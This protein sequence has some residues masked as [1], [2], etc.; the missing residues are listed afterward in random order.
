VVTLQKGKN[1]KWKV[2]KLRDQATWSEGYFNFRIT[3]K[4][5]RGAE[6]RSI[7]LTTVAGTSYKAGRVSFRWKSG[8]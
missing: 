5:L 1:L 2:L 7:V 8:W 4:V 6:I 3:K